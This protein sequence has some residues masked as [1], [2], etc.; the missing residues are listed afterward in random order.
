M[1]REI[2]IRGDSTLPRNTTVSAPPVPAGQAGLIAPTG[3]FVQRAIAFVRE[4]SG[5]VG[6]EATQTPEFAADPHVSTT[7]SGA[8]AVYLLQQ[9]KGIPI[10]Q[11]SQTV[12]FGHDG[13][14]QETAGASVVIADDLDL[15]V[16]VR[17]EEAARIAARHVAIPEADELGG[18]DDFGQSI[19]HATWLVASYDPK[20]IAAFRDLPMQP[21]VLE[22]GPFD[23]P[24]RTNLIWFP[25]DPL[26][27]AWEVVLTM[28]DGEG[29]YRVLVDAD[30][31]RILY[32][33]QL[34]R[35]I[36]VRGHLFRRD[37]SQ[38]REFVDFPLPVGAYGVPIPSGL[39]PTFPGAWTDVGSTVGN[40][41][42]AVTGE[43]D[44]P[45]TAN[46]Q[47]NIAIFDP[48][49]PA[50]TDQQVLNLFYFNCY[51]HDYFYLL[52]FREADG[53]FQQGN[54]SSGGIPGDRL[55]ARAFAGPVF[56][57]ANMTT[58]VDGTAPIMNMGL[59]STTRRH[60]ALDATVVMHEFSHGVTSRLVGGPLNNHA[61][62]AAQSAA[63][64]E[65]WGDYFACT[66]TG[67]DTVASWVVNKPGGIRGFRYDANFPDHFGKIGTGRYTEIHNVG[68]IWAA[69][70][71]DINR[72]I[73]IPLTVQLIVDALK[74][75]PAS[76]TFLDMRDAILG[77]LGAKT[78]A[79][80]IA[81][82]LA[83]TAKSALWTSF[84]KFG[85]GPKAKANN[86]TALTGTVA[87]FAV[88]GG[89]VA[90]N[91]VRLQA[92]PLAPIPDKVP[93]GISS[94][95]TVTPPG[96]IKR[97]AVSV[98]IQHTYVG[99]LR[100]LLFSPDGSAFLLHSEGIDGTADLVHT[101]IDG[102]P[103]SLSTL[104]GRSAQGVWTLQ[105]ADMFRT[106]VGT[107]RGWKLDLDL[108]P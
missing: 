66:I 9:Y 29:Q 65:G 87:D 31:R 105:V 27:L 18:T 99:D 5:P 23:G 108:D 80:Q 57:T 6:L 34:V 97:I 26:R 83:I 47:G 106:S 24:V 91:F 14:L 84:A 33:S 21:T 2:D 54:F 1:S 3:F 20:V 25:L 49:D 77:A 62:E 103:A 32:V 63:M 22:G 53:N 67:A 81:A 36:A 37:P 72:R 56:S 44:T 17:P 35:S 98:D 50:G 89:A 64:G 13:S 85:M 46:T 92:A 8:V 11:A 69:T 95:L 30:N 78:A 100:V 75:S 104:L 38:D 74:I 39:P 43:S 41:V 7:S 48:T 88:P 59:V 70:L 96:K 4:R 61:L 76:P 42:S 19:R 28:P 58:P 101:Y 102:D 55:V 94:S 40:A 15:V 68:E 12:R 71:L 60:T 52:G 10:F 107:L 90:S 45:A 86:G 79:G 82:D 16:S 93:A 51:L 73:G